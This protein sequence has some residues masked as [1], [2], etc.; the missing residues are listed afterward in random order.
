[1]Q[2][3]HLLLKLSNA[4]LQGLCLFAMPAAS[5]REILHPSTGADST[6]SI[7][8]GRPNNCRRVRSC[9]MDPP[10]AAARPARHLLHAAE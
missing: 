4:A 1:M 8:S 7:S 5:K 6:A 2:Q 10:L 3:A 9:A